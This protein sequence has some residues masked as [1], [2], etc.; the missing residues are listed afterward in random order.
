MSELSTKPLI[1]ALVVLS[2]VTAAL[3]PAQRQSQGQFDYYVLSLS[4]AP[5]F[6]S[7][8]SKAVANPGECATGKR[9]GFVV[10]GL[11]PQGQQGESPEFCQNARPVSGGIVKSMLPTMMSSGLI[12]HEW[13]AH[14]TCSGVDAAT[15]FGHVLQARSAVQVP[16][17]ISSIDEVEKMSPSQIE[18]RF[19]AAN[20]QFPKESVRTNC[21]GGALTEVRIC[22]D[23]NLKSRAC[24]ASAGECRDAAIT[25]RPPN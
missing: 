16:V 25:I 19:A 12:Q 21:H 23:K 11:W 10:H 3:L 9:I 18:A 22:F 8:H 15:Y 24:T 2:A 14:G 5:E 20:P 6:C 17:E 1:S 7:D 13:A 4:W